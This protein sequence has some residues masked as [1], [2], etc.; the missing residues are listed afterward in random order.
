MIW[1]DDLNARA[2][3]LSGRLLA[4]SDLVGLADARD[5]PGLVQALEG[6]GYLPHV[7]SPSSPAVDRALRR[8]M[9][10]RLRVLA[11]WSGPRADRLVAIFEDEDRRSLRAIL[12]GAAAGA[13]PEV[14]LASLIPTPSLPTRALEEL[15]RAPTVLDVASLL[16]AWGHPYGGAVLEEARRPRPD[17]LVIDLEINARYFERALE[18]ARRAGS[19]LLAWVRELI[20]LE[21]AWSAAALAGQAGGL[22]P[23]EFFVAGGTELDRRGFES[24]VRAGSATQALES[25]AASF[26]PGPLAAVFRAGAGDPPRLED[27][28]LRSQIERQVRAARRDPL[29]LAPVLAFVLRLRAEARDLRR[30]LWGV[31]LDA[32]RG[33]LIDQLVTR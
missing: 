33:D 11:H 6:L 2:R 27:L 18:S 5:L 28:V 17:P 13:P 10:G 20:D 12:H 8:V 1:W 9:A 19:G 29:G 32:P 22:D 26:A 30:I 15:V 7:E 21:N 14:R 25:V 23:G 4:S 16:V 31:I 24:A 3:G